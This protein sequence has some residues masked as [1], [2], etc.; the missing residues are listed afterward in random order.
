MKIEQYLNYEIRSSWWAPFIF[1]EWGQDL[2]G[3]Y[4]LWKN[5][6]QIRKT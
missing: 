2:A 6:T 3:S 5:Q 4:F 1:W